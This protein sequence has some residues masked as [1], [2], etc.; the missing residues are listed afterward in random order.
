[1]KID[2]YAN[3]FAQDGFWRSKRSEKKKHFTDK[4]MLTRAAVMKNWI[5]PLWGGC[6]TKRLTV[7]MI[8]RA[9]MGATSS[10]GPLNRAAKAKKKGLKPARP[11]RR[12]SPI[13]WQKQHFYACNTMFLCALSCNFL[14]RLTCDISL[15]LS[16]LG[17]SASCGSGDSPGFPS[18]SPSSRA[19]S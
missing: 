17:E 9:M 5:V 10:F 18:S 3:L 8:D 12:S 7:K 1:M 11:N 19:G 16:S 15:Q 6:N 4:S 14:A 2:D 13:V